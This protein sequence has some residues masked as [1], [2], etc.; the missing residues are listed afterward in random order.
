MITRESLISEA[1][2]NVYIVLEYVSFMKPKLSVIFT[3]MGVLLF[4]IVLSFTVGKSII[5]G[6]APGLESF[7]LIHFL[8]YLFFIV[9]PVEILVPYYRAVGYSGWLIWLFAMGTALLAQLI[10]YG[11]GYFLPARLNERLLGG[12][13]YEK[14]RG[15]VLKY[16]NYVVLFFN[17]FPLSSPIINFIAGMERYDFKQLF[18]YNFLGLGVKYAFIIL[19]LESF[20]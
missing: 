13:V 6:K 19:V 1:F 14:F 2:V 10:D 7:A 11:M 16:G 3:V 4:I 20:L 5:L 15:L 8:G 12:K 9:M 17:L 18:K